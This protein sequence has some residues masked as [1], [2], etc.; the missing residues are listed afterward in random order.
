MS[1]VVVIGSLNMDLVVEVERLPKP[2]ETVRGG[3]LL[4]IPGGKGA[5][6]AAAISLLGK[7]VSLIGR[8]GKDEFGYR[9]INN[10]NVLG[11]LTNFIVEDVNAVTGSAMI[12]VDKTGN[13]TIVVSSGAN[14]R[15]KPSD[16]HNAEKIIKE[17]KLLILQLEI[18]VDVVSY[19]INLAHRSHVPVILNPS[20]ALK[21]SKEI[22][23]KVDYLILNETELALISSI[24]VQDV[25][26]AESAAKELL[27]LGG[28]TVIVTL[29]EKGSLLVNHGETIHVP[30]IQV[31]AIDTTAAGDAFI[32]GFTVGI[33]NNYSLFDSVRFGNIAGAI[34]VTHKGAQT[35]LPKIE[36]VNEIFLQS[37]NAIKSLP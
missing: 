20:P 14:W 6:Q 7:K 34:T 32:G 18:P 4:T 29:G 11:V 31:V 33:L 23:H 2:G 22:L 10:L 21:L 36:E 8:V 17:A 12:T 37:K 28:N 3:D 5:N 1:E 15:E 24:E 25:S 30:T 16:I 26:S 35:S 13:N 9:L 19:A 27:K